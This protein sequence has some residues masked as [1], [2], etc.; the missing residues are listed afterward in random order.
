MEMARNLRK[1]MLLYGAVVELNDSNDSSTSTELTALKL[2]VKH[3]FSSHLFSRP[4]LRAC[5]LKKFKYNFVLTAWL[6]LTKYEQG[7]ANKKDR[8]S[9]NLI[10]HCKMQN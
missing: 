5:A 2:A 3:L 7:N 9:L 1:V 8:C 10:T 4:L 6:F